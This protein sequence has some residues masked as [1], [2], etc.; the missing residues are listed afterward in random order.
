MSSSLNVIALISGG[1]DSLFSILHCQANGHTVVALANLYPTLSA[2]DDDDIN[3]Y[4]YQTVGH[5]VIPLYEQALHIPLFRQEITGKAVNSSR[6]YGTPQAGQEQDETEDLIPLLQSVMQAHPEANA[7]STGA[8]LSTYQR[9]RVESVALRLGLTPL[10]YLWQ[11]PLLPPY[12]QTSLLHDMAAVGQEA[13]II[14]TASG[15][16]DESFL[17]F[18][19][20]SQ[21]TVGRLGKAISRFGEASNG[22]I[23]GEGGEFETLALDGPMPLWKKKIRI[24]S[25]RPGVMEGGQAVLKIQASTLE[26]KREDTSGALEALRV[27]ALLD[28]EFDNILKAMEGSNDTQ[29]FVSDDATLVNVPFGP[30]S[31]A[32]TTPISEGLPKNTSSDSPTVF[33]Y[34]NL[35]SDT[36]MPSS[37]GSPSRQLTKIF[38]RLDHILTQ[39]HIAKAN[40]NHCTLLLRKMADFTILNPIYSQFFS[41]VNPPARVTIAA[42]NTMPEGV[43]VMLSVVADKEEKDRKGRAVRAVQRQGLHVQGRSY[44]A[45]ANIGP[46]SQAISVKLPTKDEKSEGSEHYTSEVVYV[47]GQIPLIPA[48]MEVYYK[49]G[50]RG[51]AILSLQ[52]LWRIGQVKGVRWWT[53]AVGFIPASDNP[54]EQVRIAQDAWKAIHTPSATSLL[55]TDD[56]EDREADID[57]WD[58]L[59]RN[60]TSTFNDTTYRSPIPDPNSISNP[61]NPNTT[62]IPPCFIAQVHSLPRGVDIEWSA[63]GL[64]G[65][66]MH[67]NRDL[68]HANLTLTTPT[69]SRSRF[70]TLEIREQSDMD[71]LRRLGE[72]SVRDW[73][74]ATLYAGPGF[75][76]NARMNLRGVQWIP[77][78]RVWGECGREV[79][80]VLVGRVDRGDEREGSVMGKF[81]SSLRFKSV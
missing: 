75:E 63:T 18:D 72:D 35:T 44:W 55:D 47:A 28:T 9:T 61:A 14:K 80:G 2:N 8:I 6:D 39:W 56:D 74:S 17:G 16:L 13:I 66:N 43:D 60:H 22:A 15:G 49:K 41:D 65:P 25:G 70:Y 52:H 3:S 62:P 79:R 42:G 77:C 1:K 37:T 29:S 24:E 81:V 46:Y 78:V 20:A 31:T 68:T 54:E 48:S 12:T 40:I 51:Q 21:R 27:P 33:I 36:R 67:F 76:W 53:T 58:R 10:S 26:N 11:Y 50:F 4:M 30:F 73:T 59:N 34:S 69:T 19:V 71:A 23:L 45:P 38:L 5:S 32:N 64:T 57:P 7:V